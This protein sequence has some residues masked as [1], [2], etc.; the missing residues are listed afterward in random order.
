MLA[1]LAVLPGTGSSGWLVQHQQ[2]TELASN[3]SL[4]ILRPE[5]P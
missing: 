5:D 1:L 3:I 2:V 4:T